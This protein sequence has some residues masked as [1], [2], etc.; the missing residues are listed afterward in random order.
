MDIETRLAA[1]VLFAAVV[2]C[3]CSKPSDSYLEAAKVVEVEQAKLNFMLKEL[4][5]K[6]L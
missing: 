3:G 2:V 5:S 4:W 1:A 6:A